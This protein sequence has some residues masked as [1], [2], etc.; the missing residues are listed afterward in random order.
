[1]KV[2]GEPAFAPIEYREFLTA[3][4]FLHSVESRVRCATPEPDDRL[5]VCA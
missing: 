5:R 2:A 1:M 4:A 3:R